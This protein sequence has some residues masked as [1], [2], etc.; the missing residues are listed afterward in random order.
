MSERL[1]ALALIALCSTLHAAPA[2]RVDDAFAD[3]AR[4]AQRVAGASEDAKLRALHDFEA[5]HASLYIAE[6]IG[7]VHGQEF[8][9]IGLH[10]MADADA[11]GVDLDAALQRALAKAVGGFSISLADFRCDFVVHIAPTFGRMDGAGRVVDGKPSLVLGPLE[12]ASYQTPAQLP[13]FI[14]HELFHRYHFSAAGFSDDLAERDLIWRALWAE[15]LATYASAALNP[16][17]P[18]ADALLLPRDLAE[19]A[20]PYLPAMARELLESLDVSS[21]Q[22][23]GL[24]FEGGDPA[25]KARGWPPRSGYYVGYLVAR[26]LARQYSLVELAHLQGSKLRSA[27][28]D[29][30]AA[31]QAGR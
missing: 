12:I 28:G 19:R 27:V 17:R 23:F 2:C 4:R 14:A 25:A 9:R 30:L 21:G 7:D 16:E 29:E 8:D 5:S 13:V 24:F 1:V 22:T 26:R 6:A 18:L 20:E 15:G 10:E 3:F 31:I 11:N